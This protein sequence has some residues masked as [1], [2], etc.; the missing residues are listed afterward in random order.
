M[1]ETVNL[2]VVR[3]TIRLRDA[4]MRA[5]LALDRY[6]SARN[7]AAERVAWLGL[8][9]HLDAHGLSYPE[10]DPRIDPHEWRRK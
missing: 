1:N 2:S 4:W 9:S 10:F 6:E 7:R 3:K 5:Y 8:I